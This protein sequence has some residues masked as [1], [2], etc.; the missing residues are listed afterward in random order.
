MSSQI[1]T[2]PDE[3]FQYTNRSLGRAAEV[4]RELRVIVLILQ[5]LLHDCAKLALDA[6]YVGLILIAIYHIIM[7]I[8]H[9]L[10]F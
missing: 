1:S 5:E 9:A 7:M 4:I 8:I 2:K 6:A 3:T 10:F